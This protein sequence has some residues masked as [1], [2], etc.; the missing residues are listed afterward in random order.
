[1]VVGTV[2]TRI[3]I[4]SDSVGTQ[5]G[6]ISI[7]E[8]GIIIEAKGNKTP[9]LFEYIESLG[10]DRQ[11]NLGKVTA[12]IRYFDM[13]SNKNSLMFMISDGSLS[14]LKKACGK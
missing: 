4:F 3:P 12:E 13:G 5:M 7:C 8:N 14:M 1:M 2:K 6:S 9:V 11:L 10:S